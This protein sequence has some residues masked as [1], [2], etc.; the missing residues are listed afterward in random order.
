M[1]CRE[2]DAWVDSVAAATRPDT[3][4]WCDGSDMEIER[5]YFG[6]PPPLSAA[7]LPSPRIPALHDFSTTL[8]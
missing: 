8:Q 7:G 4:H 3:V 6:L 5:L 2:L 1:S